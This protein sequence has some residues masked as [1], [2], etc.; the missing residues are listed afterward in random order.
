MVIVLSY[1]M[2]YENFED[3][4]YF[5]RFKNEVNIILEKWNIKHSAGNLNSDGTWSIEV[6]NLLKPLFSLLTSL[7]KNDRKRNL[8]ILE[9][10]E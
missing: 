9:P 10:L 2:D 8:A 4:E 1:Y 5:L 6:D 7:Y 3:W